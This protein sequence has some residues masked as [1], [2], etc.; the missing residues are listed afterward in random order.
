MARF[1]RLLINTT[2]L[3]AYYKE[4]MLINELNYQPLRLR[5]GEG[6]REAIQ[7]HGLSKILLSTVLHILYKNGLSWQHS[8]Q[9]CS[10][11]RSS[12]RVYSCSYSDN[13]TSLK[14]GG[15]TCNGGHSLNSWRLL[16]LVTLVLTDILLPH[17]Q[18]V[19]VLTV[20]I[21]VLLG[22][23]YIAVAELL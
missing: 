4:C 13:I 14:L 6:E 17:D 16:I 15:M 12:G 5:E 20:S 9:W 1:Y 18:S 22:P 11:D 8:V 7:L 10:I 3:Y 19:D 23:C 2:C 21:I